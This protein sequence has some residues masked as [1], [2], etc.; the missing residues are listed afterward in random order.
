MAAFNSYPLLRQIVLACDIFSV[1]SSR[2]CCRREPA[3]SVLRISSRIVIGGNE[4]RPAVLLSRR[5]AGVIA[6]LE[7]ILY[8]SGNNRIDWRRYFV[9]QGERSNEAEQEVRYEKSGRAHG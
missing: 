7:V 6:K 2:I 3:S 9:I 1:T 8:N 4:A 5:E